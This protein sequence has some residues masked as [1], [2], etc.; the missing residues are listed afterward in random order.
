LSTCKSYAINLPRS[1]HC[2]GKA[3]LQMDA[4][5]VVTVVCTALTSGLGGGFVTNI[6][7]QRR[8]RRE[9]K[10]E[11]ELARGEL[12]RTELRHAHANFI[13]A[14]GR[15]LE[16]GQRLSGWHLAIARKGGGSTPAPEGMQN[17]THEYLSACGEARTKLAEVLLLEDRSEVLERLQT[18]YRLTPLITV[19][20]DAVST[21]EVGERLAAMKALVDVLVGSFAP[22]TWDAIRLA[23]GHADVAQ[24][25]RDVTAQ[26]PEPEPEL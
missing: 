24:I 25:S 23:T 11:R 22:T 17:L 18:L 6:W 9:K 2:V 21:R 7:T 8:Q 19:N 16:M 15:A 4:V 5:I 1:W 13:G 3:E 20:D 26:L 14:Y 12:H 10:E